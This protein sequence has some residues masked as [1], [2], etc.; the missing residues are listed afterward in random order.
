MSSVDLDNP[1]QLIFDTPPFLG[2][3]QTQPPAGSIQNDASKL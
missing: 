2:Q 3:N 1:G